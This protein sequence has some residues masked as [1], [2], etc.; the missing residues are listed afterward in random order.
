MRAALAYFRDQRATV[1]FGGLFYPSQELVKVLLAL[2]KF[3]DTVLDNRKSVV[4]PQQISV[5]KSVETL[6]DLPV[7]LC[8]NKDK[9]HRKTLLQ[10]IAKKFMKPLFTNY[11]TG[12][13]D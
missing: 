10:L 9:E 13:T 1:P 12:V 4:K 8:N 7:L 5:E 2:R 3:A 11:A 6:M